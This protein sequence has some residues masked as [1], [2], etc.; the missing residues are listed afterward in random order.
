MSR[1]LL[2]AGLTVATTLGFAAISGPAS[3]KV[4]G[5]PTSATTISTASSKKNGTVLMAEGFTIYT[6]KPNSHKCDAKCLKQWPPV[7]LPSGVTAPTAGPGV[8]QS[9]LGTVTT[10]NGS[11]QV[12]YNGK[13]LYWFFKDK[14]TGQVKGN[15]KDKWGK[16][17]TVVLKKG[18]ASSGGGGGS[19]NGTG[20]T[21]F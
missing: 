16:W 6:L 3:A 9:M 1:K 10:S 12:T 4:A 20:G 17:A 18:T 14:S 5:S 11:L 13:A 8:N 7:L 15:I 19:N 2:I 21:S